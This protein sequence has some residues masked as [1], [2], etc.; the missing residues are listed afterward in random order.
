MKYIKLFEDFDPSEIPQSEP[1]FTQWM[2]KNAPKAVYNPQEWFE[3]E[4][5]KPNPDWDYIGYI[6]KELGLANR[7]SISPQNKE[8][9]KSWGLT[10][11]YVDSFSL[12]HWATWDD[13]EKLV[14]VLIKSGAKLDM[15]N[16]QKETPLHLAVQIGEKEIAKMLIDAGAELDLQNKNEKTPLHLAVEYG[17]TNIAKMLIEV[18]KDLDIQGESKRSPLHIAIRLGHTKMA[19]MLIEAGANVNLQDRSG[20]TPLHMAADYNN[21]D[22]AKLLIEMGS[23]TDIEDFYERTPWEYTTPN[24]REAVPELKPNVDSL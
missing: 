20:Q 12:L 6:I 13:N 16:I 1:Q 8:Y 14:E 18:M 23:K 15:Q 2:M 3:E 7:L 17:Y 24:M 22:L 9:L 5:S 11:E 10:K 21:F 19:K 4:I